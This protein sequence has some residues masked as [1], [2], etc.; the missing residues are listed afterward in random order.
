[1]SSL[2]ENSRRVA[3]CGILAALSMAFL[4]AGGIL[5]LATFCCP[6][7]AMLCQLP[8]LEEYGTKTALLFYAAVVLLAL[9][10]CPDKE[11]AL[12]YTF[13]GWHPAIRP[14]LN[15]VFRSKL[16]NAIVKL[17]LFAA[18]VTAMYALATLLLGMTYITAEYAA[19][20]QILLALTVALACAVWLL[21]DKALL[22][23]TLLYRRK[24]R[25]KLF[26]WR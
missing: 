12:L 25:G 24:W 10:L 3:L 13:L 22:R 17:A 6:I 8:V 2:H 20:G 14:H 18:S 16:I 26:R 5:P 7:L 1:M 23:F 15:R 21:F 4:S 19:G 11:V 9:L